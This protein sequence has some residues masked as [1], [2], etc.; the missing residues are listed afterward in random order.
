LIFTV[1]DENNSFFRL[2]SVNTLPDFIILSEQVI[3][4]GRSVQSSHLTHILMGCYA[5][6]IYFDIVGKNGYRT[7]QTSRK[8]QQVMHYDQEHNNSVWGHTGK[9]EF[10]N[11]CSGENLIKNII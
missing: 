8:L 6:Y 4:Q 9:S 10:E 2:Q 5:P 3:N 1:A 11:Y 7:F